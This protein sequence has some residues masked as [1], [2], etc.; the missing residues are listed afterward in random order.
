MAYRPTAFERRLLPIARR[1]NGVIPTWETDRAGIDPSQLRHWASGNPDVDHPQRGIY[2]WW[3][4]DPRIRAG[5]TT[6]SREL[7][8][9]GPDAALW[10]PSV[11]DLLELGTWMSP[12]IFIASPNR[13]RSDGPLVYKRDAGFARQR[14]KGLAAQ[15]TSDALRVSRRYMDSD[16]WAEAV[17]DAERRGLVEKGT[18]A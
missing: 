16:K 10:G 3:A 12:A 9:A 18:I 1:W 8:A 2:L 14:I 15:N 7:A 11:V 13:R 4:D 5:L 17:A 6:P